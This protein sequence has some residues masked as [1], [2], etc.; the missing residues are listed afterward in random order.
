MQDIGI[1]QVVL[2]SLFALTAVVAAVWAYRAHN[3][4]R[5]NNA[6]SAYAKREMAR[7]DRQAPPKR[8]RTFSAR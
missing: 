5:F 1:V 6:L 2:A 3:A 4:N 8:M 7:T